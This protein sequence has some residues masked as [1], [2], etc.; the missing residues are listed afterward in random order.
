[1]LIKTFFVE[2]YAPRRLRGK[3]QN[4][5]RLYQLCILRF[6]ETLGRQPE[7]SDLNNDNLLKHLSRRSQVSAATRNKELSQ[8]CALWR[9]AVQLELH[10]GWPNIQAEHEPEPEPRAWLADD[11]MK[12]M[13]ACQRAEG[14]IGTVPANLYWLSLIY[15]ALDS[16]ERNHALLNCRWD[17][18]EG[19]YLTVK[20]SVRKGKTR[21]RLYVLS[22][23]T[24]QL[25]A[26]LKEQST[27]PEILGWPLSKT[28]FFKRYNRLLAS[29]GLPTGRTCGTH[30]LRKTLASTIH[31]AGLNPQSVLDHS[32]SRTTARY[33]DGRFR[34]QTEPCTII[35]KW[36]R[37]EIAAGQSTMPVPPAKQA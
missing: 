2:C 7:L 8:L 35:A 25:L 32:D 6:S 11:V 10:S 9:L 36:L 16:G 15:L 23:E 17:W 22:D 27:T 29:A 31:S 14:M 24:L 12:L 30:K 34:Q 28:Y 13:A 19:R 3:S 33:L 26:K 21:D 20:A 37:G 5:I 18:L 1:M 4:S